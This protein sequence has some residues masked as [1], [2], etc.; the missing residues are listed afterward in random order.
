[1]R[2][3]TRN[4]HDWAARYP[5]I[6]AAAAAKLSL[7]VPTYGRSNPH[8]FLTWIKGNDLIFVQHRIA[9]PTT[10]NDHVGINRIE[11]WNRPRLQDDGAPRHRAWRRCRAAIELAVLDRVPSLWMLSL[12]EALPGV[13]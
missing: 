9:G 12:H 10:E 5:A 1:M 3:F 11:N 2:L 7:V 6:V 13:A 8:L 4:G